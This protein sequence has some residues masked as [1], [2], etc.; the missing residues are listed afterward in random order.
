[1]TLILGYFDRRRVRFNDSK[2]QSGVEMEWLVRHFDYAQYNTPLTS[3][4]VST[5][6]TVHLFSINP[7]KEKYFFR[8][9]S[10]FLCRIFTTFASA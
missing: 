5:P 8:A 1:M 4:P 7:Q 6:T 2:V 9:I 3:H 10:H